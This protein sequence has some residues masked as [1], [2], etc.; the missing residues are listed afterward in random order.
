MRARGPRAELMVEH[1]KHPLSFTILK[2]DWHEDREWKTRGVQ[3]RGFLSGL[4]DDVI[5]GRNWR[6]LKVV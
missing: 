5:Q 4:V 2:G 3:V 1:M 6:G